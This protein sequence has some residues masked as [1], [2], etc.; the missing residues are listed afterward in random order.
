MFVRRT[1]ALLRA[2]ILLTFLALTLGEATRGQTAPSAPPPPSLA[3]PQTRPVKK[4]LLVT[5]QDYPGHPGRQ[6]AP[7]LRELLE[8]DPRLQV[9]MVEDPRFLANQALADYDVIVLHFMNWEQPD[10]GPAARDNLRRRV[11]NGA[12]LVLVH[13]ACGAFQEWPDFRKLAGRA[14]DPKLRGHDPRGPFTVVPAKLDHPITRG[15][16]SFETDDELYTCLAGD[17]PIDVLATARSKVDNLDYPMAFVLNYG[18]GRVFHSVLGHD[19]KAFGAAGVG[20][21]YRR[22]CAWTAGLDPVAPPA[23]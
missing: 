22:G 9:R 1:L 20:E 23:K 7:V 17:T 4:V 2:P 19:V 12:G 18:K 16:A 3:A 8:K 6:T 21:L 13:F 11:E 5:G 14:W 15:L 10:P